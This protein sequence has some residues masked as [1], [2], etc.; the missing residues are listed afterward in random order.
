MSDKI[1]YV[2]VTPGYDTNHGGIVA[3]HKLCHLLNAKGYEAYVL[4]VID[5]RLS[6]A[7][8]TPQ[9]TSTDM[10]SDIVKTRRGIVLYPDIVKENFLG[11]LRPVGFVALVSQSQTRPYPVTFY[12]EACLMP[13]DM[14]KNKYLIRIDVA[15]RTLFVK[16]DSITKDID[17]VWLGKAQLD[18]VVNDIKG[19]NIVE[20]TYAY[21]KDRKELA[22]LLKRSK[23]F[24][25]YD[26]NTLMA[27]EAMLCGAIPVC[28]PNK[29][30][31]AKEW[32]NGI[33]TKE[34]YGFAQN[35]SVQEIERARSTADLAIQEFYRRTAG[36]E[37]DMVN[38]FIKVTQDM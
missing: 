35:T 34:R 8:N 4:L 15:D 9:I 18:G 25:T 30:Q 31:Y 22:T 1:P 7:F 3:L 12:W 38:N 33:V 23:L 36:T 29:S 24:Y 16:D 5:N 37:E 26:H 10:I 27:E 32:V 11:S 14:D 19:D 20:I 17:T 6:P 21:P 13:P 28:V 2:I